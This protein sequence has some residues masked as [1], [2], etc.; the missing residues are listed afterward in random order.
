MGK[1]L[2]RWQQ[3][4]QAYT[5]SRWRKIA[6]KT[7]GTAI[8]AYENVRPE[9]YV[10]DH[11][12]IRNVISDANPFKHMGPRMPYKMWL[13]ERRLFLNVL[14][15]FY[16]PPTADE[17]G[18]VE[19]AGD[20]VELGRTEEALALLEQDAPN[21]LC[22]KCPACGVLAGRPCREAYEIPPSG[23][24]AFRDLP[25]PHLSRVDV[26]LHRQRS[27]GPMFADFEQEESS[28]ARARVGAEE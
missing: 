4:G 9:D 14:E 8:E 5:T 21:R 23:A 15:S 6:R 27:S 1:L 22:R 11:Q 19:V 17:R 3:E 2:E 12:E 7:I 10:I 18:A 28:N 16:A 24:N 13:V 25:V 20:L 26:A